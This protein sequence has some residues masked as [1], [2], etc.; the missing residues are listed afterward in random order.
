MHTK[1]ILATIL[2]GALFVSS[3]GTGKKLQAANHTITDLKGQVAS[4]TTQNQQLMQTNQD[5]QQQLTSIRSRDS[6]IE[7]GLR[8]YVADCDA[9]QQKLR[10]I[11]RILAEQYA[12]LQE[13]K[14]KIAV[15]LQDFSDRG[16]NVYYKDGF[17]FVDMQE[18]LLYASGSSKLG[19]DG[20]KAL[21]SLAGALNDYPHLMVYIVGNTD[22]KKFM[23]GSD[24]WTL[25]TERANSVVRVLRDNYQ[26]D[27]S[28][29]VAAGR[30]KYAPVADNSTADGRAQNRR[31]E[32]ILQPDLQKLW[33]S[34][35]P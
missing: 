6:A 30:G 28:R 24:N 35:Q 22:D 14:A 2:G 26:V 9:N 20:K 13:M 29:L 1:I 27:P 8:K 10:A 3:C 23:G 34:V 5:Q 18:S 12:A 32:I 25:S 15:A 33:D 7:V 11:Q 19:T 16:V 21:G 4:L 17:V 31:T